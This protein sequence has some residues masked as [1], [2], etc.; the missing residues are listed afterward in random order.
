M[1]EY[2]FRRNRITGEASPGFANIEF[3][4]MFLQTLLDGYGDKY[5]GEIDNGET[6]GNTSLLGEEYDSWLASFIDASGNFRSFDSL[7]AVAFR[8]RYDY[9]LNIYAA[10]SKNYRSEL[11]DLDPYIV[12][13]L[14]NTLTNCNRNAF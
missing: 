13:Q 8:E 3:E 6:Y 10:H 7:D 9:F 1:N 11:L 2:D 12:Q 4:V 5:I 14:L